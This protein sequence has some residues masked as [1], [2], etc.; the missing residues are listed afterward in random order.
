MILN[1]I[2]NQARAGLLLLNT[3]LADQNDRNNEL[4]LALIL[5]T[6]EINEAYTQG[7]YQLKQ[8]TEAP[9]PSTRQ[10]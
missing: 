10:F 5:I 6:L 9:N 7:F 1:G 8:K 3:F 4:E 2:Y